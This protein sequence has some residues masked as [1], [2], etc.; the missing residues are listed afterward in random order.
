MLAGVRGLLANGI[1]D[2][3]LFYYSRDWVAGETIWT[4]VPEK[5]D[6]L[7]GKYRSASRIES[8]AVEELRNSLMRQDI[9]MIFLLIESVVIATACERALAGC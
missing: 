5:L 2:L 3:L 9:C 6:H 1:D 7:H 4:P 8:M